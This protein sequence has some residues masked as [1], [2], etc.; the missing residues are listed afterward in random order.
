MRN[1]DKNELWEIFSKMKEEMGESKLLDE[2]FDA[3]DSNEIQEDLAWICQ[4]Y[5]YDHFDEEE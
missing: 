2:L 5:G 1:Y 4:N 3:M